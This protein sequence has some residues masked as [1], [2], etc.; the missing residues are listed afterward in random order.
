MQKKNI[1]ICRYSVLKKVEHNCSCL[2]CV[3]HGGT[4]DCKKCSVEKV[5]VKGRVILHGDL[6]NTTA[7]RLSGSTLTVT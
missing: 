3:L 7:A 4:F 1:Q 2:K 5:G 6:S